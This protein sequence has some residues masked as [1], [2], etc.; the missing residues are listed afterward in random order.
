MGQIML[1]SDMHGTDPT[2]AIQ[3]EIDSGGVERLVALGDYDTP[4]ILRKILYIDIPKI[5]LP[6][7]HEYHDIFESVP[8]SFI[9]SISL[10]DSPEMWNNKEYTRERKC[11][12]DRLQGNGREIYE[13]G[14]GE[15]RRAHVPA[16]IVDM[17]SPNPKVTGYVWCK[18]DSPG[19]VEANLRRMQEKDIW[20]LIR[21]HDHK[22]GLIST[23]RREWSSQI[24]W[25]VSNRFSCPLPLP[26]NQRHIITVGPFYCRHYTILDTE[27]KEI[28][29]KY[30][31]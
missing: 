18:M 7:N 26:T 4:D 3:R 12:M 25:E 20:L 10:T 16:G 8:D 11:M 13:E 1:I 21:G 24:S 6:G 19:V 17:G 15:K 29:F 5:T 14:E 27:K 28:E 9:K 30:T 2:K 22:F 23:Q 31:T